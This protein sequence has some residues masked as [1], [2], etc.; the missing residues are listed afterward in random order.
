MENKVKQG[1]QED[2]DLL[3]LFNTIW[4]A[5][6]TVVK[7]LVVFG[8][9]GLFIAVFSVK[10]YTASTIVV[11]QTSGSKFGGNLGGLAAMAGINLGG[12]ATESIPPT[13]YPKIAQSVPFQRK[14]LQMPL[15]FSNV[16]KEVT[17]Q[18]YY[19][20][21]TKFNLL[22]AI[23]E[24]TIGLP[25]K[26]IKFLKSDKEPTVI[27]ISNDSIY[28]IT[29]NEHKLFKKIQKQLI[30]E[31]NTRDGFVEIS[32]SMPEALAAAQMT[33]KAQTILQE[34][35]TKFKIEKAKQ[36]LNFI[37]KR[38][39]EVKL[40]FEKKQT[41]L[42]SYRDRNQGLITSRSQ[43]Y[44]KRIES[45][46]NLAFSL[47]SELAKQLETQKIQIKE[48]TP[49]FTVIEPVSVPVDKSKPKRALIILVWVFLGGVLSLV[50]ILGKKWISSL[51]TDEK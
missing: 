30:I 37:Q 7:F 49:V 43:S 45:E 29:K 40:E 1:S 11:P 41:I 36:E 47:Y 14:L 4:K 16:E 34:A 8:L 17:Y 5:R 35:I 42:A 51:N 10:E 25:G 48:N 39:N 12:G 13:L 9:I 3:E 46:Y 19:E 31:N 20:K 22:A 18:E 26:I 44:L 50:F 27:E 21:Y 6:K 28:R 2:I 24:Y 38:Y 32:F 33:K 15:K 23:K